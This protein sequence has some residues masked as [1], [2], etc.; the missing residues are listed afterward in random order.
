[1]PGLSDSKLSN[2]DSITAGSIFPLAI[3]N[4]ALYTIVPRLTSLLGVFGTVTA[5][6][7]ITG[8]SSA[9]VFAVIST[10]GLTLMLREPGSEVVTSLSA[11]LA[12]CPLSSLDVSPLA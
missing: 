3:R 5:V 1:M 12:V 6:C 7:A 8:L 4:I 11:L 9:T 2:I 10:S